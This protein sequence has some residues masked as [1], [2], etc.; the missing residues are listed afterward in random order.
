MS[1]VILPE[2]LNLC[3]VEQL[4][5]LALLEDLP[6]GDITS[7]LTVPE[8]NRA[9]ATFLAKSEGVFCGGP[10]A[11]L[12]FQ[13]VDP[14][15]SCTFDIVD[16]EAISPGKKLGTVSGSTRSLLAAERIALNF[17][18]RLSGVATYAAE[19]KRLAPDVTLLD[20]RKTLPGWRSLEKYAAHV[21]GVTNHRMHLGDMIMIKDNHIDACGGDIRETLKQVKAGRP[22]GIKIE[23]EVRNLDELRLALDAQVDIVMLDNMDDALTKEALDVIAA[24]THTAYVEASG[25]IAPERANLLGQMG[26]NAVSMSAFT[27]KATHLD[28]SLDLNITS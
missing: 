12:V 1:N 28:I 19:A 6:A 11:K 25:G 15:L 23:M 3:H 4:I 18:Q 10:V 14:D 20:T 8:E 26:V 9:S 2:P 17:L 21:G 5:D 13:K 22:E 16:G 24:H 27:T 7:L